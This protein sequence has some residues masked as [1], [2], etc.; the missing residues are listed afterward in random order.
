MR[1]CSGHA[2]DLL[3]PSPTAEGSAGPEHAV[4]TNLDGDHEADLRSTAPS[5]VHDQTEVLAPAQ[6]E[7]RVLHQMATLHSAVDMGAVPRHSRV[8]LVEANVSLPDK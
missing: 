7:G 6:A 4:T 3:I 5:Q 8:R 2:L 1:T